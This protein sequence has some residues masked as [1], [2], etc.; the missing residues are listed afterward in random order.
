MSITLS[1]KHS[2]IMPKATPGPI[3]LTSISLHAAAVVAYQGLCKHRLEQKLLS[4]F[5]SSQTPSRGSMLSNALIWSSTSSDSGL[6]SSL[7]SALRLSTAA[8]PKK[9]PEVWSHGIIPEMTPGKAAHHAMRLAFA[10][11]LAAL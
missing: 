6:Q 1:P 7:A 5:M 2:H 11:R 10:L 9:V 4:S 3:H 8:A